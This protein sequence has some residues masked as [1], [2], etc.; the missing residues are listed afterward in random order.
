MR[1]LLGAKVRV[2]QARR[3]VEDGRLVRLGRAL[4]ATAG[5]NE[6]RQL[7]FEEVHAIAVLL[8]VQSAALRP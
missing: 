4:D 7:G 8:A 3:V 1:E 5:A 2:D 6:R